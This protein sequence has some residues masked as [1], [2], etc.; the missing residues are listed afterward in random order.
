MTVSLDIYT[1]AMDMFSDFPENYEIEANF[2]CQ[3]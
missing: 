1:V 3:I 2:K